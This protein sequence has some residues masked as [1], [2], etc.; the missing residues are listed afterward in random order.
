MPSLPWN[1]ERE[2]AARRHGQEVQ[3]L[4][5]PNVRMGDKCDLSD[6]D[7]EMIV[8]SRQTGL[9]SS[10]TANLLGFLCTTEIAENGA[11]NKMLP[12]SSSSASRNI[13]LM[14]EIR[15]ECK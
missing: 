14:R 3:L 2:G 11:K 9:S 12:V 6:F 10:E 1:R 15:G 8:G 4:F 13:L 7:R 5:R